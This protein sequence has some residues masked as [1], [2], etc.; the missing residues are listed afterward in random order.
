MLTCTMQFG[1]VDEQLEVAAGQ[2]TRIPE[3]E[4]GFDGLG[5]SQGELP[6]LRLDG[7]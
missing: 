3:L 4:A 2:L 6:P 5:F 7:T 1:N